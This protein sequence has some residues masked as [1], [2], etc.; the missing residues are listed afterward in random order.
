MKITAAVKRSGDAPF[1]IESLEIDAP[2]DDEVL[3]KIAGV[4]ICHT[5]IV[6]GTGLA[7]PLPAVLGHEGSGIVAAVGS[8]VTSVQPGDRVALSFRSCGACDRC[9]SGD[10]PYCRTMPML[11]YT[12]RRTDGSSALRDE[13]GD[14][15]SNFFGQS[16][17]ADHALT[18]ERNLVKVPEDVP[19][20]LV[21]PL[22]CGV[23]TGVGGVMNSLNAEAGSSILITGGGPV[24]LSA[25]LGAKIQKCSTIILLEPQAQRR[26]LGEEF[27]ATHALDPAAVDSLPDAVRAIVAQ[28]VDY[29]FDT[30]GIPAVLEDVMNCLGSKAVFGIVGIAPPETKLPG[31][32]GQAMTFG[33]TVKGIIEGDS[34]PQV[35]IPELIAHYK[36]GRL[37][38]DQMIR[39]YPMSQINQAIAEQHEGRCVKAVLLPGS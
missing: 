26:A 36:V 10:A 32:L 34:D 2:R 21:G 27:G 5:D 8:A 9:A 14:I 29:A 3:V 15:S 16:S 6:F 35:F 37:P 23:Q 22:G 13:S 28:G 30:T 31:L 18:Y 39:T 1:A 20:E 38:F 25:V 12:G 19:L 11:N 24:G 17:F 4:G 33:H 7:L